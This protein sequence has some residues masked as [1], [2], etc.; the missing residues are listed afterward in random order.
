MKNNIVVCKHRQPVKTAVL[1]DLG[2]PAPLE[3][4][5]IFQDKKRKC[6]TIVRLSKVLVYIL[7]ALEQTTL[8]SVMVSGLY[9]M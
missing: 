9:F 3:I 5:R 2:V 7:P 8:G 1:E 4:N 6:E